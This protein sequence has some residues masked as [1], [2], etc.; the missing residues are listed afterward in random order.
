MGRLTHVLGC[1][2]KPGNRCSPAT[3]TPSSP[4]G[5][6][7][8]QGPHGV[9]LAGDHCPSAHQKPG[10]SLQLLG[11]EQAQPGGRARGLS[12]DGSREAAAPCHSALPIQQEA[13]GAGTGQGTPAPERGGPSARGL[14]VCGGRQGPVTPCSDPGVALWV[15]SA[16]D[17][18]KASHLSVLTVTPRPV[19][20][21]TK[22]GPFS[23][24]LWPIAL[25]RPLPPSRSGPV[26][27]PLCPILSSQGGSW[28]LPRPFEPR[29]RRLRGEPSRGSSVWPD[30]PHFVLFPPQHVAPW[31]FMRR[32]L[33]LIICFPVGRKPHA[34]GGSSVPRAYP[35]A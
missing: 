18:P 2:F 26:Q 13:R 16:P 14:G 21:G 31:T 8:S 27:G 12:P 28:E 20:S 17:F 34:A 19:P 5:L 25:P 22:P 23:P 6:S 10:T 11:L 7:G 32:D 30:S 29:S 4:P 33:L 1:N 9:L 35:S 3:P 24:A 15:V